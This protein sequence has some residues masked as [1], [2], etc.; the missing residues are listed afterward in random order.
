MEISYVEISFGSNEAQRLR[1]G[2]T[3]TSEP[4]LDF[5]DLIKKADQILD[6][7]ETTVEDAQATA[8]SVKSIASKIDQGQGT[9]G[10]LI[11]DKTIYQQVSAGVTSLR[12]NMDAQLPGAR[13]FQ[14]ARV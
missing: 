12:E 11:N 3:I 9:V 6:S 2:E 10:A 14:K 7:T 1:G 4:P 5:S 13:V 8:S